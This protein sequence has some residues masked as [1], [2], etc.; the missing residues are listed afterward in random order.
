MDDACRGV[1]YGP[2]RP[3]SA[4]IYPASSLW[5]RLRAARLGVRE[6]FETPAP[7]ACPRQTPHR[8]TPTHGVP[9][10]AFLAESSLQLPCESGRR[11]SLC[12]DRVATA[13]LSFLTAVAMSRSDVCTTMEPARTPVAAA[14]SYSLPMAAWERWALYVVAWAFLTMMT[15]RLYR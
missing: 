6:H 8:P 3:R 15:W 13:R 1:A 12:L 7:V 9:G 10:A 14:V 5:H 11:H 2:R 4:V